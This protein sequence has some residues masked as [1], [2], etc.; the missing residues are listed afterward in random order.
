MQYALPLALPVPGRRH[1]PRPLVRARPGADGPRRT[2]SSS[3]RVVPRAARARARV[4]D[5]LGAHA[6]RPRR[7]LRPAARADRRDAER[8]RPRLRARATGARRL[9]PLRRRDPA[10]ARTRSPRSRPPRAV[11][12]PLVVAGPEKDAALARE[13]ARARRRRCA[14]TSTTT[15]LAE[16]VPRRRLPRAAVALRGL[17]PA[18][19]RG[20]GVRARRSSRC[21]EPALRRG[22]RRRRRLRRRA[23]GSPTGSAA[24]SPSASAS[25]PPG[26]SARS[27]SRGRR[28]RERTLAVYREAL[29]TMKV[30]AVVVSHGHARELERSLPA[31]APQVDEL[32]VVANVPGSVGAVPAGRARDRERA[33]R[34]RFAAN[35]NVGHRGDERRASSSSRTRTP[36]PSRDAVATL[37]AFVERAPALRRSPA[38][39]CSGPTAAGSR[40]GAASRRSRGTLV[41][42]TP[43]RRCAGRTST[44]AS[45]TSSTS[46]A[47]RARSRRDW[48]LGAFLLH[49]PRDARRARRLGR[50]A[51]ATTARTSTS[52]TARRRPAGSAGTCP[53]RSCATTTRP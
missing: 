22:R 50:R 20:D 25:S 13:L 12:L 43:L 38:R 17:R 18:R 51:S 49:A 8:R 7:A 37:A 15:E 44:S 14:A 53:P 32:V 31:L 3:A 5:R 28:R 52:A 45:T 26:S 10:R 16:L 36:S 33:R 29:A 30:S 21:D 40:R 1:D 2:G 39:G 35:V 24:R 48:M 41:R 27:S 42:R 9:R 23:T 19:A 47:D 4:L 34:C 6:A 46:A 11:G